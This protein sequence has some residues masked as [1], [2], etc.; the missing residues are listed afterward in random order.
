MHIAT[1]WS[2]ATGTRTAFDEAIASLIARLGNHP[3]YLLIYFTENYS[4][5][6][7]VV[8]LAML[9]PWPD[10]RLRA[11]QVEYWW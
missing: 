6:K 2:T 10:R 1:S 7:L 9:P 5:E 11:V 3:D 8:A 4:A